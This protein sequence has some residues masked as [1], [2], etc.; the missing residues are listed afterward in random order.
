[1]MEMIAEQQLPSTEEKLSAQPTTTGMQ[2]FT[3]LGKASEYFGIW[4]VNGLLTMLTLGLYS[5]WA[6]VR[7]Q[8]YFYANTQLAN[9]SFQFLA[10]PM[11]I[12]R[13][14]MIAGT[15]LIIFVVTQQFIGVYA[16]AAYVYFGMFVLYL[17][18]APIVLVYMMSFRLRYSAWRGIRFRFRKDFVWAYRVYLA[19]V[20]VVGLIIFSITLPI[21]VY[22]DDPTLSENL[23]N[24]DTLVMDEQVE[25]EPLPLPIEGDVL[26]EEAEE[27]AQPSPFTN[28]EPTHFIPALVLVVVFIL[29]L[30]YFSFINIRFL[31]A[32][33]RFGTA[34]VNFHAKARDYYLLYS[35]W[36][37]ITLLLILAWAGLI[38]L[39]PQGEDGAAR[40]ANLP[41]FK[42]VVLTGLYIPISYAY[43]RF[44]RYN[45]L[46]G[47]LE[48]GDGHRVRTNASFMSYF[49]LIV[50]NY[51]SLLFT[52]GFLKPWVQVRTARYFLHRTQLEP[53]GNLDDFIA[54]QEESMNALGEELSDV[55]DLEIDM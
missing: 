46:F 33:T 18:I 38:Y 48:I 7:K 28:L 10:T 49:L 55:F 4:F 42:L 43:L 22:S 2:P 50:S 3:F 1:M 25:E 17:L 32:N 45:L 30:P 13:S 14:R 26:F 11:T 15:L 16:G 40:G 31:A 21:Y 41:V 19:P 34:K 12:F 52:F 20:A 44:K 51:L 24:E 47:S 9:S 35:K 23:G 6:K 54:Q 8:Q 37:L 29:L 36:V 5:P 53:N 27:E 39:L